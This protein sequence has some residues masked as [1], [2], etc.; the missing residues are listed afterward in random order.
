MNIT[1]QKKSSDIKISILVSLYNSD[2]NSITRA[3]NSCLEQN[4]IDYD[5]IQFVVVFDGVNRSLFTVVKN[6]LADFSYI[7]IEKPNT[8]LTESLNIGLKYC[9]GDLITRLDDDDVW[10]KSKLFVQLR[11]FINNDKL[12]LCGTGF[13]VKNHNGK[14]LWFQAL[15]IHE[16]E[17]RSNLKLGN[18]FCHSSVM[19]KRKASLLVGGYSIKYK[20]GQD[21]NLWIRMLMD[22]NSQA[23][24][25]KDILVTRYNSQDSIS[26]VH[27]KQ[28]KLN[29]IK[30]RILACHYFGFE[31]K[32]IIVILKSTIKLLVPNKIIF[33]IKGHKEF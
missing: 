27:R 12:I 32:S 21:Y 8:G 15:G 1:S 5:S 4:S 14:Q 2:T 16:D 23:T 6:I 20:T 24:V 11:M 18:P 13:N 3:L 19:F 22:Y 9:D 10:M 25:L 28:Q 7:L 26:M 29:A 33:L 30:N 31:L 17:V